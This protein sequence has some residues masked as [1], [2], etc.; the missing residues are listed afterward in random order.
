MKLLLFIA[1]CFCSVCAFSQHDKNN[2]L[3]LNPENLK[4]F[5]GTNSD[6]LQKQF[7]EYFNEKNSTANLLSNMQGRIVILPQD[8][9]PCVVPNTGGIAVIPNEWNG[10]SVPYKSSHHPIPNPALPILIF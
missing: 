3:Q 6:S 9:M 2:P 7:R 8:H 1:F 4:K 5:K 10:I